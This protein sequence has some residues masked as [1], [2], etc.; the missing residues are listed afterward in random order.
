LRLVDAAVSEEQD[1]VD[2]ADEVDEPEFAGEARDEP[3]KYDLLLTDAGIGG[4]GGGGGGGGTDLHAGLALSPPELQLPE[5][6]DDEQSSVPGCRLAISAICLSNS[7]ILCSLLDTLAT[8]PSSSAFNRA[9]SAWSLAMA[10]LHR[11]SSLLL[12]ASSVSRKGTMTTVSLRILCSSSSVRSR[13]SRSCSS[14]TRRAS[15]PTSGPVDGTD[16]ARAGC[17]CAEERGK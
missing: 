5:L 9:F 2:E 13:D 15:S 1:G 8:A 6:S 14:S 4:G 16:A 17:T 10:S 3:E 7:T 12:A 11:P